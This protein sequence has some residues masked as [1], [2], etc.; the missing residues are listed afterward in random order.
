MSKFKVGQRVKAL[1]GIP[2]GE[3]GTVV[4]VKNPGRVGVE[5]D[6]WHGGHN[7]L[8][9]CERRKGWNMEP[10]ELES[11]T[12]ALDNLSVGDVV[13]DKGGVERTVLAV[14]PALV[15]LSCVNAPD[16][17]WGWFTIADLKRNG[18]T[19]KETEED[20]VTELTMDEV[21]KLAGVA[22][23]KLRIRKEAE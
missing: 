14:L 7:L 13:V 4:S 20:E 12:P 6:T 19:V 8:G 16:G 10:E 2:K 9:L 17:F 1:G 18:H 11:F 5:F 21:A 3:I 22:V 15:G 23:D